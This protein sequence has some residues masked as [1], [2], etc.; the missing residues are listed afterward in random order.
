MW[1]SK[2]WRIPIS[3]FSLVVGWLVAGDSVVEPTD[4]ENKDVGEPSGNGIG[5]QVSLQCEEVE[6]AGSYR[7]AVVLGKRTR[8]GVGDEAAG[9]QQMNAE[10]KGAQSGDSK[11]APGG[12]V[13]AQDGES[14]VKRRKVKEGDV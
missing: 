2:R 13:E 1:K 8:G 3:S 12:S 5:E 4:K 10:N 6:A 7:E 11:S 9:E 14:D